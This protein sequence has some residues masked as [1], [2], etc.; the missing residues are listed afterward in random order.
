MKSRRVIT[1]LNELP[2][3]NHSERNPSVDWSET[4]EKRST[5]RTKNT[6]ELMEKRNNSD[7]GVEF[8]RF[9]SH[10][11]LCSIWQKSLMEHNVT[12]FLS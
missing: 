3:A 7:D 11:R 12:S 8:L 6:P 5:E 9:S 10:T 4:Q 2:V 1:L